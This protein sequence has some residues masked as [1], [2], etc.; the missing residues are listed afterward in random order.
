MSILFPN[1]MNKKKIPKPANF[2]KMPI[3]FLCII[4]YN[5]TKQ[6]SE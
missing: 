3:A 6:E 2:Y 1:S 4:L 5:N